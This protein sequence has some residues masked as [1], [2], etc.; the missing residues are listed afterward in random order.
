M[1]VTG[2]TDEAQR[3]AEVEWQPTKHEKAIIY[4]LA[5]TSL[6]VAL[7]ASIIITPLSVN[8]PQ[9]VSGHDL[10]TIRGAD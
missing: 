6:V 8:T 10:L 5:T 4:T 3:P 7:D 2:E 9:S 1:N